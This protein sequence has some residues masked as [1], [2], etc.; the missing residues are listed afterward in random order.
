MALF[1]GGPPAPAVA[2]PV[3]PAV[4]EPEEPISAVSAFERRKR[5]R[6]DRRRL[7]SDLAR[8]QNRTPAEINAWVN[9]EVGVPRVQD[10]S[11]EQLQRSVDL[12]FDAIRAASG[13]RRQPAGR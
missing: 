13:R 9:G 8:K 5:L 11:I 1:G 4:S 3:A 2:P 12:L 7:V 6:E 10:A